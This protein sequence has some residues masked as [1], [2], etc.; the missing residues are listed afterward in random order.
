ML[1]ELLDIGGS[2]LKWGKKVGNAE[3]LPMRAEAIKVKIMLSMIF[4][5]L[6][7]GGR[8]E[9]DLKIPMYQKIILLRLNI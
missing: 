6:L 9:D 3:A 4:T 2:K 1:L 7:Q 5:V 8:N